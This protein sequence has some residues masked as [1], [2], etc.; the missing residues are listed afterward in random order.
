MKII[1]LMSTY[2]GEKYLDEQI[3]SICQQ[4][5]AKKCQV[6][7]LVR[8]DGSSDNTQKIL[9]YY[10]NK[11]VLKWYTG[12]NLRP[13]KSFWDLLINCND[14]DYYAF[15][16]QDDYWFN[17]K[18]ERA[19]KI[20]EKEEVC[21]NNIPL[22]YCA[23]VSVTDE[24]LRPIKSK[25]NVLN[26]FIDFPHSL[27]YSTAPGCTFVFNHYARKE[28]VKYNM[29]YEFEII[30][31]WLAHKIITMKGKMYFDNSPCMYYRQH[32]NNVIGNQ[33]GGIKYYINRIKRFTKDNQCSRSKCAKSLLN[34]Y[35]CDIDIPEHNLNY[36]KIVSYYQ[37]K[38]NYKLKFLQEKSFRS[39]SIN[40]LFLFF[41]IIANRI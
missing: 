8:D 12:N 6:E 32:E 23:A 34:V 5:I 30:H 27:M 26:T 18:L 13:A 41:L 22:L 20:L 15:C 40:D 3:N 38:F 14:A 19:I 16:D 36:L 21:Y 33:P 7:L 2:N 35:G 29:N 4:T 10:Q 9:D 17:T 28:L 24:K 37:E 11:G 31:D 1:I 39:N 25:D